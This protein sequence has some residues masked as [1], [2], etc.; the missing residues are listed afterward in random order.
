MPEIP[1]NGGVKRDV[2]VMGASA[3]G[4]EALQRV[5]EDLG[6]FAGSAF[7]VL[8]LWAGAE[9][10]LPDILSRADHLPAIHPADGDPVLPGRIYVAPPD[11]HLA[12]REGRIHLSRGPR[13]NRHR[14]SIDVLFRTA[15]HAF[16]PRVIGVLLTGS[17]DDGAAGLAAIK[18]AGGLAVVQ[19]PA[20]ALFPDMPVAALRL[21]AADHILRAREIGRRLARLSQETVEAPL[22]REKEEP[23]A[24]PPDLFG[25][26]DCGGPLVEIVQDGVP[27]LR[28]TVGH[29]YSY[30]GMI[31]A[32][33]EAVERALWAAVRSLEDSAVV[34][35]KLAAIPGIAEEMG[36]LQEGRARGKEEHAQVI[37][38]LLTG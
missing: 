28:C 32:G 10:R 12:L 5:V 36:A 2:V 17:D 16:G 25:C 37:R 24:R 38:K 8:H 26:P 20:D 34:C 14:P 9:S 15:A 18:R 19:D 30:Q 33:D 31:D 27:R 35:R 4:V 13:E 1:N 6:G 3:G 21:I 11:L 22:P 7:V 23:M 29:A